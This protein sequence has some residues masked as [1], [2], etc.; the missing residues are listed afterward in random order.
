QKADEFPMTAGPR[1]SPRARARGASLLGVAVAVT[2]MT[3]CVVALSSNVLPFKNWS[4]GV[5]AGDEANSKI[6]PAT[7]VPNASANGTGGVPPGAGAPPAGGG[8]AAPAAAATDNGG[9]F[10]S[11]VTR[12]SRGVSARFAPSPVEE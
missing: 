5:I 10:S 12:P 6:L 11:V 2:L 3:V 4:S 7:P 9:G 8:A 1:L